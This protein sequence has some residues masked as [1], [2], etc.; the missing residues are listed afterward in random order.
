MTRTHGP[1]YRLTEDIAAFMQ[2]VVV[3]ADVT[4]TVDEQLMTRMN[5]SGRGMNTWRGRRAVRQLPSNLTTE[6]PPDGQ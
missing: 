1:A 6:R 4:L 2:V 5:S 3:T